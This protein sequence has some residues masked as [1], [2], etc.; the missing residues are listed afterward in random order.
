MWALYERWCQFYG[1]KRDRDEMAD[2]FSKFKERAQDVYKT[3]N[4]DLSYNCAQQ[5]LRWGQVN[6]WRAIE[7]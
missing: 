5:L 6:L 4:S 2:R 1:K 7:A 3:N